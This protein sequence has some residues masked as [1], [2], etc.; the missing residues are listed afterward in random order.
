MD[1]SII[2][3]FYKGNQFLN[4]LVE[5]IEVIAKK[6]SSFEIEWVIVNDSPSE[7]IH[8]SEYV[9]ENL[10]VRIYCNKH[11]EGIQ[12]T[13]IRGFLKSTG[14]YILFLDQDDELSNGALIIHMKNIDNKNASITNGYSENPD[15]KLIPLFKS[16]KQMNLVN[17]INYYFYLGNLIASPGMVMIRRDAVPKEWL[18]ESLSVNGADDWLLWV[19]FLNSN[20]NFIILNYKTYIHRKNKSN[21]SDDTNKMLISSK[22]ALDLFVAITNNKKLFSIGNKRLKMRRNIELKN[23]NKYLQYLKNID[24]LKYKFKYKLV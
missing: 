22:Q 2:T 7:S 23:K 17:D 5:N 24:I 16:K 13:R 1:I 4:A 19:L 10:H 18:N 12:K 20:N 8:L 15:G 11:N 21:T 14:K 9:K 6:A 3:P